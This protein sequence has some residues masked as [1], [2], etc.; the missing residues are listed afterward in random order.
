MKPQTAVFRLV[1]MA[2]L[3]GVPVR[4][5]LADLVIVE[6]GEARAAVYVAA[7]VMED[8]NSPEPG[9][10]WGV[11]DAEGN[12]RRLRESVKDLVFYV[13]KM[14]GA[15]LDVVGGVP[16]PGDARIPILI[17]EVAAERFGPPETHAVLGQGF[18]MVVGPNG[19][20]LIGES[21]LGTSYAIY[22]LL[23]R[24]GCRWYMPS[25]MG[26]V[27]PERKIV[28]LAETDFSFA[29][30]TLYRGIWYCDNDYARRNRM[31]GLLLN[32]GHALELSY[33]SKEQLQEHP[34]W[35]ATVDG[36]PNPYRLKWSAPGL[37]EAIADTIVARLDKEPTTL[38]VSLSPD[39]GLG[40]DNSPED[41]AL[42]AGDWDPVFGEVSI[43]DRLIWF[44]NRVAG[45]VTQKYPDV[46]FGLLAYVNYNRPPVREKV[47][48]NI[49][50]QIA[51]ITY[52][53]AQPMTDDGEP[54]NKALRY[55]VEGWGKA[56]KMTSYYFYGWNLA[57]PAAPNPFIT[58][59]SVDIPI[60]YEKGNCRLW[61]PETTA[62]FEST[63]HGL[64]L[65]IRLAWDPRQD[66]RAIIDEF[67]QV[68]YGHAAAEMSEYW[69][70]IDRLW[71]STPEY[72]GCGFSYMRRFTPERM[73]RARQLMN[74]AIA[75]CRTPQEKARVE[76]ADLSLQLHE[77]FMKLRW[78]LA[79]GR[80]GA[81]A[82]EARQ[83]RAW[84]EQL[85][86]DY[87]PQ[88]AFGYMPWVYGGKG[89]SLYSAYFA[90]FFQPAYDDATRIWRDFLIL[91]T[92]PLRQWRYWADEQKRG[93]AA[94]AAREDFDDSAWKATDPCVETWSTVGY[95]NYMGAMWYR[96]K[97][98]LP[99]VPQ[100][101]G[102]Y[103]WIAS[104]DGSARV[105][106][107][108][109]AAPYVTPQGEQKGDFN[110]YCQPASFDITGAVRAGENRVAILCERTFLNE[111][112]TGGLLGPVVIYCQRD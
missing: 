88:F 15:R 40:F 45:R 18:R 21:D 22:E 49:V 110:G 30:Y 68:F 71:V 48:P 78:D 12:R 4:G 54:N 34:Q 31:G 65:G 79:E 67:H 52:S 37:A 1:V 97:V 75:A 51:P 36:K 92:P 7:R 35:I 76:M 111:L 29:P 98:A 61:Q 70:F 8:G 42:D 109:Q 14:S 77:R 108:G 9:H 2:V 89:G 47:H 83:Y 50:P 33:L 5:L 23:H 107:N 62:N 43:T 56:A 105:F 94:G 72:S 41:R 106:I 57:E 64:Y 101:K 96:Q 104:T 53:R 63:L 19:V 80:F 32:A 60:I 46:L 86:L 25:E 59:W 99:Q 3:F 73:A 28:A 90:A 112:G 93:E 95:H 102:V 13:E 81:L 44:C 26:E 66:P 82:E 38:S 16:Q 55:L 10:V 20:G 27:V 74:K 6:N 103:L 11:Q 39:D 69:R 91:T 24:L 84:I 85:A 58:K 17:G 87:R 100:G